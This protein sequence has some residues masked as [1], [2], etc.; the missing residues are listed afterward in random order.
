ME[1][2]PDPDTPRRFFGK[3]PGISLAIVVVVL[4]AGLDF[5]GGLA[6]NLV[7][8]VKQ[9]ELNGLSEKKRLV[10]R[11]PY[12]HHG[13][14]P[15]KS[16]KDIS[17]G[18]RRYSIY[19]NSLGFR[20][21]STRKVDALSD[22]CRILFMGDSFTFAVGV[23]YQESFVGLV[24]NR[25][26]SRDIDALNGAA[27]SYS[28]IIYYR[29]IKELLFE[30]GLRFDEVVVFLDIGDPEDEAYF[31]AIDKDGAVVSREAGWMAEA[32]FEEAGNRSTASRL[33]GFVRD[34]TV[35]FRYVW[36]NIRLRYALPRTN[37]KRSLWTVDRAL[38]NEYGKIGLDKMKESMDRLHALLAE[39]G[40]ALT[41]AVYPWPDQIAHR[42]LDSIQVRF[43]QKWAE[44]NGVRF[45]NLFPVFIKGQ[46]PEDSLRKYY[47]KGDVH[48]NAA[49]HR[50]VA[51]SFLDFYCKR[52]NGAA[53]CR[54]KVC[55]DREERKE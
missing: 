29:R 2:T 10:Q 46:I 43:W 1:P 8:R 21:G 6:Y 51:E 28:P 3:H 38:Y 14:L 45:F 32:Q 47:I 26:A 9:K 37:L 13:L 34:H 23:D 12:Y 5:L 4:V 16:V 36:I 49:G 17:W 25:L 52:G 50:L 15:D 31:Y 30:Q 48:W 42:D 54:A 35:L 39:R 20:D 27:E 33:V 7:V 53:G 19:T 18:N 41:I 11:N 40:I 24:Q 44:E 55:D 22:K